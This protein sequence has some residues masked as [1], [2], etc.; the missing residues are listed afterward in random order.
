MAN[1]RLSI[2]I[3]LLFTSASRCKFSDN[4]SD[5]AEGM[6]E[7]SLPYQKQMAMGKLQNKDL[8]EAS[9]IVASYSFAGYF[10]SHNDS[11]GKAILYLIDSLG[12]GKLEFKIEDAT[13]RDW[14]D[15]A[16]FK[17]SSTQRST[18]IIG[19]IGD[20]SANH[21]AC[22]LLFIE[23]PNKFPNQDQTLT[24]YKK[25]VFEYPNGSRDAEALMID[26]I[27]KDIF[28]VS[29][30]EK[31]VSMYR[32]P[33][34][35][36]TSSIVIAEKV[37][38]LPIRNIT[39]GDIAPDGSAILLKNYDA[40]YYYVREGTESIMDAMRKTPL[41]LDYTREPQGEA[42]CFARDG[43]S[44]Y[45]LSEKS[46]KNKHPVLYKYIKKEG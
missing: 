38:T 5:K 31:K 39:A 46:S 22:S 45:T 35:H 28:I 6:T 15:I 24:V 11:G 8:K 43:K 17:D 7:E 14:E 30:K 18:I 40:I 12:G 19:D 10:W 23:E 2:F 44:F 1:F 34:P 3:L 21:K 42:I 20:N 27:T 25:V 16:I 9:G 32:I 4:S 36:V 37:L 33:Y 13:N 26:P 41:K 29:K